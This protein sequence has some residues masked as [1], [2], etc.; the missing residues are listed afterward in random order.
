[1]YLLG[2]PLLTYS[3]APTGFPT[4]NWANVVERDIYAVINS[5]FTKK[6]FC[7]NIQIQ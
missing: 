7:G 4:P 2:F 6:G 3:Y 5:A 1:M